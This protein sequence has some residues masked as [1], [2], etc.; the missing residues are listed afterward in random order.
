VA[1]DVIYAVQ[2][3]FLTG[4]LPPRLNSN[5]LIL[6]PKFPEADRIENFRPIALANFQ[7]KIIT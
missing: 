3:F 1:S 5:I 6:I 2:S 4:T 7:F